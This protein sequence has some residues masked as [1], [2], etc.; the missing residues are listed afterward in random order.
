MKVL[1][2]PTDDTLQVALA[3][4]PLERLREVYESIPFVSHCHVGPWAGVEKMWEALQSIPEEFRKA[5]PR[6]LQ[7]YT[8]FYYKEDS[9][10]A[11]WYCKVLF[12][13]LRDV[14]NN[15]YI[16]RLKPA[17]ESYKTLEQWLYPD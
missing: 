12:N 5:M 15:G 16:L 11:L 10:S 17:D 4:I 13:A 8:P 1:T 7:D 14:A 3:T 6:D 2:Q 9:D